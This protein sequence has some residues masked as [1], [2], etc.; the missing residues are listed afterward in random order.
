MRGFFLCDVWSQGQALNRC[1]VPLLPIRL[2]N[3]CDDLSALSVQETCT[4]MPPRFFLSAFLSIRVYCAR[5]RTLKDRFTWRHLVNKNRRSSVCLSQIRH[6]I[7]VLKSL[8]MICNRIHASSVGVNVSHM[9]LLFSTQ[10]LT[11]SGPAMQQLRIG[12]DNE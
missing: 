8:L 3:V 12:E 1:R 4:K 6:I 11:N 10:N 9:L 2:Q 5:Q 7:I